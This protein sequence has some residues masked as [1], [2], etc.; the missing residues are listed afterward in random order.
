MKYQFYVCGKIESCFECPFCDFDKIV[1]CGSY[2]C[3]YNDYIGTEERKAI[4]DSD[5][6]EERP[7]WCPLIEVE[8]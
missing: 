2:T 3:S 1:Y 8:E 6:F 4:S 5:V 7:D